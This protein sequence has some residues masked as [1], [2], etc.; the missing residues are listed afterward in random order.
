[1][2]E[3]GFLSIATQG[4]VYAQG[5]AGTFQEVFQSA[6]F[7]AY[8]DVDRSP[9]P[10]VFLGTDFWER[11]GVLK[12]LQELLG[13]TAFS[14]YVASTD[15]IDTAFNTLVQFAPIFA[16]PPTSATSG[17]ALSLPKL[18]FDTPEEEDDPSWLI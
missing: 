4:I 18:R 9:S 7:N 14:K 15:D 16:A 12:A 5:G 2:R 3:D 6:V 11:S 10:M 1:V 8:P 13:P 17:P